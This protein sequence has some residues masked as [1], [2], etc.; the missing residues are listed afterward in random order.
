MEISDQAKKYLIVFGWLLIIIILFFIYE[1]GSHK[2]SC[3]E[4]AND[5]RDNVQ[6]NMLLTKKSNSYSRGTYFYGIDV[7]NKEPTEFQDGGGWTEDIFDRLVIG[8]TILKIKGKYT[9]IIKSR[10]KKFE[11]PFKCGGKIYADK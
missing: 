8:D 9:L 11:I 2:F 6:F 7:E 5:F 3:D 1:S 4:W 10:G